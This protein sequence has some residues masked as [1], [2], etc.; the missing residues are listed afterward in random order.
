M[1]MCLMSSALICDTDQYFGK[2]VLPHQEK[3]AT[4]FWH[5]KLW[6]KFF[7]FYPTIYK[8]KITLTLVLLNLD[9]S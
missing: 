4:L 3:S 7:W 5:Y 8:K 6:H 1:T 9:L 2:E